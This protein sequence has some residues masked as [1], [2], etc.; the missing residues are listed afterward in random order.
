MDYT[1]LGLFATICVFLVMGYPVAFTLA[2]VS[3]AF[4]GIGS[5]GR[6]AE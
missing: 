1:A 6:G 2:G 3:L 4:A 5:G